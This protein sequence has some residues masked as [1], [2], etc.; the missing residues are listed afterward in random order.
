LGKSEYA[1]NGSRSVMI[2]KSAASLAMAVAS[3]PGAAGDCLQP[4]SAAD[5]AT[6]PTIASLKG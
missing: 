3:A 2:A 6:T 5:I 1:A 4:T